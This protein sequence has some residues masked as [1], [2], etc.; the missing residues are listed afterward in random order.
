MIDDRIIKYADVDIDAHGRLSDTELAGNILPW[1]H[2][3]AEVH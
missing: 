2:S 1:P 3:T